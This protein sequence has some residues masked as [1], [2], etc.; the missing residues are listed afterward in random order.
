MQKYLF[1]DIQLVNE[2]KIITTDLL[3]NG[4]R[5]ERI[6][7]NI[8]C[9]SAVKEILGEGQYLFPGVI[10]DQVHFREPG[11]THKANIGTESRA[12]VAGGVTS[13][14]EMPNTIPNALTIKLLEEKYAI[15]A[16]SSLAGR[17]FAR[18][19]TLHSIRHTILTIEKYT[20]IL[21]NAR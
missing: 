2:G 20:R 7:K 19:H 21:Y 10:D 9:K 3:T 1:K 13:F 6:D 11:L 8:S 15:A 14:M 18:N 12:A 4:D 16:N 5:I 17:P